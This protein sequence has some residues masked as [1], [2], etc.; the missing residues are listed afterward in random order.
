M[1]EEM[2]YH[3]LPF[4]IYSIELLGIIIITGTA[5]YAFYIF[6]RGIVTRS[7]RGHKINRTFFQGLGFG[8]EF[9]LA[10]E[11]LKTIII[12]NIPDLIMLTVVMTLRIII[13]FVL[14]WESKSE[15][16]NI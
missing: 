8:L 6:I 7:M 4:I 13:T 9:L 16:H 5:I 1:L 11:I 14:H 3:Y 2:I 12:D 15:E 10:G